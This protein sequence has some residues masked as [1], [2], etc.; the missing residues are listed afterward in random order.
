MDPADPIGKTLDTARDHAGC[1]HDVL[2]AAGKSPA[3][4]VFYSLPRV[5]TETL[6]RV[7][8]DA[9]L[10]VEAQSGPELTFQSN[11]TRAEL[12]GA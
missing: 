10:T 2:Q 8:P 4:F 9:V 11:G 12:Y 7:E 1:I 3:S 6:L 5:L